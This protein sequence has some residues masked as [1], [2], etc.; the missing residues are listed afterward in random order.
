MEFS[1]PIVD[2]IRKRY[3]CR[4]YLARPI[5]EGLRRT[6]ADFVAANQ[7][8]PF[9]TSSRFELVAAQEGDDEAL[10]GLGTYGFVKN[11]TGFIV[12]AMGQGEKNLEDFGYLMELAILRA[13]DLG[14]GTCWLGGGFTK[15]RFAT[16]YIA[17]KPRRLDDT[18]R[19]SVEGAHRLPWGTLFFDRQFGVPLEK[20]TAAEYAT[21]LEM[22]RLGP[23][24][25]NK[26][27]WRIV[28]DDGAWH[29]YMQRTP[30]YRDS[31]VMKLM[32]VA[33]VQRL[34][35]GIAMS[36]FELTACELGLPGKWG[37]HEPAIAKPD[38]LTEYVVSWT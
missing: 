37:G 3:S 2:I 30:G 32:R 7:S 34:D 5:A 16:G 38:E 13:T 20:E 22:V 11:P 12:G 25:S 9:G 35:L 26:Q 23:S 24:A 14:L 4:S 17:D 29:F 36:H 33:D 1:K 10:K 27:P 31:L 21:P 19:Q 28:R 18:I 6:L 15:S 8:G